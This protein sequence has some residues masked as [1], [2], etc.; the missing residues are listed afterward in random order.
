MYIIEPNIQPNGNVHDVCMKQ[1]RIMLNVICLTK[2]KKVA[3]IIKINCNIYKINMLNHVILIDDDKKV[4]I[5]FSNAQI[6]G[7]IIIAIA[8]ILTLV[9]ITISFV[10][11]KKAE[12]RNI[13]ITCG[14]F[15]IVG[16]LILSIDV[17]SARRRK[18][19]IMEET[20][21]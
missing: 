7:G 12:S 10:D 18:N 11:D 8:L 2:R 5:P 3:L 19:K 21:V 13:G 9:V 20:V 6:I 16:G 14:V 4:H 15:W 1:A 17:I